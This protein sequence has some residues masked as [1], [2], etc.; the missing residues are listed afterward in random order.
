MF[1]TKCVCPCAQE[2]EE[3]RRQNIEQ[4]KEEMEKLA[5][6]E[7]GQGV[8]E[9]PYSIYIYIYM[10][11]YITVV[12]VRMLRSD[13]QSGYSMDFCLRVFIALNCPDM[14]IYML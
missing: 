11:I 2:W 6:Y 13:Q 1:F 4:M 10:Y 3:K 7:R 5:E 12:T 14:I 8:S 9:Q